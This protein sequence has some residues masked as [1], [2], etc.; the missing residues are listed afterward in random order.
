M[1]GAPRCQSCL[2]GFTRHRVTSPTCLRG[3][4]QP[5]GGVG[6]TRGQDFGFIEHVGDWG[7]TAPE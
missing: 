6:E 5:L 1:P 3:K 2:R 4:N 7:D